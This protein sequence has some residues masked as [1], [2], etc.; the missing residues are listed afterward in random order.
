MDHYFSISKEVVDVDAACVLAGVSSVVF[1]E[2]A[3]VLVVVLAACFTATSIFSIIF[4]IA[5]EFTSNV[6]ASDSST[7]LKI[8]VVH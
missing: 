7:K 1:I 2:E 6:F 4:V 5:G 8:D 3:A